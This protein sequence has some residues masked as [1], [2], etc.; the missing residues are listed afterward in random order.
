M[1]DISPQV[2]QWSQ[3]FHPRW[4]NESDRTG[5]ELSRNPA[6]YLIIEV[7]E[8]YGIRS[9]R[10]ARVHGEAFGRA[11]TGYSRERTRASVVLPVEGKAVD[12]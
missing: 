4:A 12:G 7:T 8:H 9:R 2:T 5:H 10:V 6:D 3:V 1:G 11:Q